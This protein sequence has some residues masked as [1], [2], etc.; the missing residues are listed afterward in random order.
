MTD[1]PV[2]GVVVVLPGSGYTCDQPLL[3][4]PA[5]VLAEAGW[6]VEPV[7]WDATGV[8]ATTAVDFVTSAVAHAFAAAPPHDRR[9]VLAKSL[10]TCAAPWARAHGIPGIWLT[11]LLR[12]PVVAA[13]LSPG[14]PPGLLV[15]GTADADW[16]DGALARTTGLAMLE[17]D[18]LT[19]ALAPADEDTA[20]DA[21]LSQLRDA[22]G[23]FA[24]DLGARNRFVCRVGRSVGWPGSPPD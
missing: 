24:T 16:W 15:G 7:T 14:G 21:V 8:D 3:R 13:A 4:E 10:G 11:P 22:V 17:F 19:H 18:G 6:H 5:A 1:R 9:L 23:A 20:P 12:Q 2:Q